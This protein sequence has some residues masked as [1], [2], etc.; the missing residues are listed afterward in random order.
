MDHRKPRVFIGSSREAQRYVDAIHDQLSYVAEVTPWTAGVFGASRYTLEELDE[1]LNSNDFAVFVFAPDD[2]V[3]SR[4]EESYRARDNTVFEMGMF[5]GK[6]K[7]ERVFFLVPNK[8]PQNEAFT[9]PSDF[10]GLGSLEYEIRDDRNERAAV[11]RACSEIKQR[12][13][14]LKLH[15]DPVVLLDEMD[16][17]LTT[18]TMVRRFYNRF[19][20]LLLRGRTHLHD[21]LFQAIRDSHTCPA[22]YAVTGVGVWTA[23]KEGIQYLSGDVGI[24]RFYDFS[25]NKGKGETDKILV[26]DSYLTSKE[27]VVELQSSIIC[28]Y[29]VCYPINNHVISVHME[30]RTQLSPSELSN[31]L[32]ANSELIRNVEDLLGEMSHE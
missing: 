19:T 26:V 15:P 10:N 9:L 11:N 17:A 13:E 20:K 22:D 14:D 23:T 30:G 27:R 3:V 31:M 29:L 5:W 4:G 2:L 8:M 16:K 25:V 18:M 7:R 32:D 24:G 12:I 21:C 1:Q 6:L 28:S